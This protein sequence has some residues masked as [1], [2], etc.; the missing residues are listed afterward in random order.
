MLA[1]DLDEYSQTMEHLDGDKLVA[2]IR[3]A[4]SN[5]EALTAK[6]RRG[7][8]QYADEVEAL[9]ERVADEALALPRRPWPT[10]DVT[11]EVNK[12]DE[13]AAWFG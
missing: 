4:R 2:Q 11:D 10:A 8:S 1:L 13:V 5:A 7:T 9:L 6:I 12:P 3:G